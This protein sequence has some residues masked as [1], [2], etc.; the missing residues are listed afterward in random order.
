[1]SY[2]P[3]PYRSVQRSP[4]ATSP[5]LMR[6]VG[7]MMAIIAAL[8]LSPST[9]DY[10]F[11]S[12][13]SFRFPIGT[14]AFFGFVG[15]SALMLV[16]GQINRH[17]VIAIILLLAVSFGLATTSLWSQSTVYLALKLPLVLGI[18]TLLFAAG[19][20]LSA[21]GRIKDL[22]YSI[23]VLSSL[24][25]LGI[26]IFGIDVI[27]GFQTGLDEEFGGRY[28]SISRVL[29]VG[30][31]MFAA[32]GISAGKLHWKFLLLLA[33]AIVLFQVLFTGGRVGLLV[34]AISF[35]LLYLSTVSPQ[36]RVA[37]I[38]AFIILAVLFI[39]EVDLVTLAETIW[40]GDLPL[41]IQR[42]LIDYSSEATGAFQLLDR[43]NLWRLAIAL[44]NENPV[45][46]VGLA[47]YPVSAGIGDIEG[48]YPHNIILEL[49]AETGLFGLTLFLGFVAIV[50]FARPLR[51][52]D[53]ADRLLATGI[54]A[55]GAAIASVISD[56]GLQRELF[57]GLGLYYGLKFPDAALIRPRTAA[58]R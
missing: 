15:L 3:S 48:V 37:S 41:T 26:W 1:M 44:W 6:R 28:Q 16:T 2:A 40:P 36:L 46:G 13:A 8:A 22:A 43:S 50:M 51:P 18:P 57:L 10:L 45:F 5:G 47:G 23:C 31:V 34:I 19:F 29:A 42:V 12:F 11:L 25:L 33:S 35:P 54:L 17:G 55:S 4:A 20:Y 24:V 49:A 56:F 30:A 14:Y 52:A 7:V 39:S 21:S 9:Y 38:L 58:N 53:P 32:L 27:V